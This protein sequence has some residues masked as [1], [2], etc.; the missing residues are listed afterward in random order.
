MCVSP[1][2]EY[3]HSLYKLV[4][5]KMR[6]VERKFIRGGFHAHPGSFT[7][8]EKRAFHD[9]KKEL[10]DFLD[11]ADPALS[12]SELRGRLIREKAGR[13][14]EYAIASVAGFQTVHDAATRALGELPK[15][16]EKLKETEAKIERDAPTLAEKERRSKIRAKILSV[17]LIA[18][19]CAMLAG[20]VIAMTQVAFNF[21]YLHNNSAYDFGIST[22]VRSI[23]LVVLAALA[24]GV[25]GYFF[26]MDT[27]YL[28][29]EAERFRKSLGEIR[30]SLSDLADATSACV[31]AEKLGVVKSG[32]SGRNPPN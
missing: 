6:T 7:R 26:G 22:L 15:V 14:D 5:D 11:R 12:A 23:P 3:G 4:Y 32:L 8:H 2:Q 17:P 21:N 25:V 13:Y 20:G 16:E 27:E 10:R 18:S 30:E 28:R 24:K 29:H 31:L 1:T 9:V 19:C